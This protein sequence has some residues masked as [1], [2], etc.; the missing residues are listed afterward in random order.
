MHY[1]HKLK[2]IFFDYKIK[3]KLMIVYF[4][5]FLVSGVCGLFGLYHLEVLT[6]QI[7]NNLTA[8]H[9]VTF[10]ARDIINSVKEVQIYF[11]F[12]YLVGVIVSLVCIAKF[13]DYFFA[14]PIQKVRRIIRQMSDGNVSGRL[15]L[16]RKDEIGEVAF[17][18][19]NFSNMMEKDALE[20]LNKLAS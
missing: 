15:E 18:L 5:F 6:T 4:F 8:T 3:T 9:P 7:E 17:C 2:D 12:S 11:F 10:Q 13:A 20:I 1:I 16:K 19:D 14:L